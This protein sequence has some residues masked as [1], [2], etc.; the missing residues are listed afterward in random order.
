MQNI[1]VE[2][3]DSFFLYLCEKINKT[4]EVLQG[5]LLVRVK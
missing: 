5:Q 4:D 2:L 3:L 1:N